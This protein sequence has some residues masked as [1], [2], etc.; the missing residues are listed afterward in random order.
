MI[1]NT[2]SLFDLRG[3]VA[4]ITGAGRGLGRVL[5]HGLAGAGARL[6][7]C[8]V[9]LAAAEQTLAL[10]PESQRGQAHQVDVTRPEEVEALCAVVCARLGRIDVWVNN[11][12]IDIIEPALE[13]AIESWRRVIDV[14]L[15]GAFV[16][17]QCAGRRMRAQGAET[18][19]LIA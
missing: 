2:A 3:K 10:L 1:P 13:V 5:A 6:V 18:R 7:L 14:D 12:A 4:V 19:R 17:A 16:G 15:T 11:A 9:N 8:D